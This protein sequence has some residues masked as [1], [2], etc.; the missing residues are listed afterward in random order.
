MQDTL[1]CDCSHCVCNGDCPSTCMGQTCDDWR[2]QDELCSTVEAVLGCSCDGCSQCGIEGCTDSTACNYNVSATVDDDS[3]L[4][5]DECGVCGGGGEGSS[6]DSCFKPS[7]REDGLCDDGN[8]NCTF[9]S[10]RRHIVRATVLC[11]R[12]LL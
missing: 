8:N 12:C 4:Y 6:K 3:C 1:G 9:V 2:D 7:W 11:C 5:V 10:K